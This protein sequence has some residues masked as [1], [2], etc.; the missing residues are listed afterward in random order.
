MEYLKPVYFSKKKNIILGSLHGKSQLFEAK[1]KTNCFNKNDTLC[2]IAQTG[3]FD[4]T[5]KKACDHVA[6]T[7][8]LSVYNEKLILF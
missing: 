2:A 8:S 5:T 4:F 3:G 6:R 7:K 1:I